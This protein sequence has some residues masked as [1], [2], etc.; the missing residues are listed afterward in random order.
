MAE[1]TK[2][3]FVGS[4]V[5]EVCQQSWRKSRPSTPKAHLN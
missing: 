1:I 4:I 3:D 2:I 5:Y